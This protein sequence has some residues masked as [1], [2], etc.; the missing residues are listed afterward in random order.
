MVHGLALANGQADLVGIINTG[1]DGPFYGL[2][3]CPDLDI[4]LYALAG[5]VADRGWGYADDTFHCLE[6]LATY[7]RESW[8][9]LGDRDLATHIH[10]TLMVAD[11]A[12]TMVTA[13]SMASIT[14]GAGDESA[15][16]S[17]RMLSMSSRAP[18]RTRY[19]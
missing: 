4:N 18:S 12:M 1:D 14:P 5:V 10:R 11:G 15:S 3:V 8:F 9:G 6:G 2:L 13:P 16:P 7:G 19:S 17:M